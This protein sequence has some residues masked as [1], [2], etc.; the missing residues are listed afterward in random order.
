[1][2]INGRGRPASYSPGR[3]GS[4][5]TTATRPTPLPVVT[6]FPL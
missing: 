6:A 4:A 3:I 2:N 1:M 5:A